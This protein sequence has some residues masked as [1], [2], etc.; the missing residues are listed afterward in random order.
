MKFIIIN[1]F[2]IAYYYILEY[3]FMLLGLMKDDI[4]K[5]LNY[6]IFLSLLAL[7]MAIYTNQKYE[8]LIS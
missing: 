8:D 6:I 7:A 2:A 1:V 5:D 3:I 4:M